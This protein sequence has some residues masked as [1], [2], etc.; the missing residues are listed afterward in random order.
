MDELKKR[1]EMLE[2]RVNRIVDLVPEDPGSVC[3]LLDVHYMSHETL[4]RKSAEHSGGISY[5]SGAIKTLREEVAEL[6]LALL[7]LA[8]DE[9]AHSLRGIAR[10]CRFR[11][12]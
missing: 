1:I 2:Q 9:A 5:N 8:S 6:K 10:A 11:R 4:G 7:R 12:R 3:S